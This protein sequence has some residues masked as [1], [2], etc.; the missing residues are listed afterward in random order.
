MNLTP[1][2]FIISD[3]HFGH[4]NIVK[5]AYRSKDY[6]NLILKYWNKIIE[7][8]DKV[9]VLGDLSLANKEK[10]VKFCKRLKGDKY[11]VR[12]NHDGHSVAWYKDCEFTVVEPIYKTFRTKYNKMYAVLFTHEPVR[13]L[14]DN[15]F[16][17]HG[18]IH[19]GVH[20]DY[21]LTE[22]HF[23]ACVEPLDYKPKPLYEILNHFKKLIK[24]GRS[25]KTI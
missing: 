2:F 6:N 1:Q 5:Y 7:K 14:P 16:N 3:L 11:L 24:N 8:R 10:T 23:N 17:I 20:R 13:D 4:A 22:R 21:D 18:H 19:R 9:L 25:R 12:G 15:W